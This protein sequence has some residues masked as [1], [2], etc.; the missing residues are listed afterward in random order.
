MFLNGWCVSALPR[1]NSRLLGLLPAVICESLPPT[2]ELAAFYKDD[3]APSRVCWTKNCTAGGTDPRVKNKRVPRF[4]RK[5]HQ[6]LQQGHLPQP[7]CTSEYGTYHTCECERSDSAHRR[8]H[9]GDYTHTCGSVLPGTCAHTL[10]H[11]SVCRQ[12]CERACCHVS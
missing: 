2:A 9:T 5:G 1:P 11:P 12:H 4:M 3:L 8:L 6:C 7:T 10:R